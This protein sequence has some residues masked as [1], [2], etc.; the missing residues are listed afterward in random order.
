M[1]DYMFENLQCIFMLPLELLHSDD[2][3]ALSVYILFV[4]ITS[5]KI[6]SELVS[7]RAIKC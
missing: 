5:S 4:K 1:S 7:K 2:S 3:F 6:E